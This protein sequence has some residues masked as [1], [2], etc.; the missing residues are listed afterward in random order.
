M[1]E[2]PLNPKIKI[3]KCPQCGAEYEKPIE[4]YIRNYKHTY[5]VGVQCSKCE[6][7]REYVLALG[8]PL[9]VDQA[10]AIFG[11]MCKIAQ[12]SFVNVIGIEQCV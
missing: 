11:A 3:T 2:D 8:L 7:K 5:A 9:P 6:Y 4:P 10:N 1:K 12:V